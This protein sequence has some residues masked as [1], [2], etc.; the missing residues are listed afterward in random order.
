V[1]GLHVDPFALDTLY[2]ELLNEDGSIFHTYATSFQ[3]GQD[4][5]VAMF[6]DLNALEV[7][8]GDGNNRLYYTVLGFNGSALSLPTTGTDF[9]QGENP[10]IAISSSGRVLEFHE[11]PSTLDGEDLWYNWFSYTP[12]DGRITN[13]THSTK[14]IQFAKG[15]NPSAC[16]TSDEAFVVAFDHGSVKVRM[17]L[18]LSSDS[19]TWQSG[20]LP[21]CPGDSPAVA[22][23]KG[24][25]LLVVAHTYENSTHRLTYSLGILH[26]FW[27][28]WIV[29]GVD[30]GEGKSPALAAMGY[31]MLLGWQSGTSNALNACELDLDIPSYI[32]G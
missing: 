26:T 10:A 25:M 3:N 27:V 17:G 29:T 15:F 31:S 8:G 24:N 2:A 6:P 13:L 4:P 5:A 9:D 18:S 22:P 19:L 30:L 11:S 14:G 16:F 32:S 20:E 7:H 12:A 23:V 1:I 21:V 28:Q